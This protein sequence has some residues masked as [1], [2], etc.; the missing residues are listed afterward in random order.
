MAVNATENRNLNKRPKGL[1]RLKKQNKTKTKKKIIN[2]YR[3][4]S[5]A[6]QPKTSHIE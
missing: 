4:P 3:Q 6:T 2:I 5:Y 1:K